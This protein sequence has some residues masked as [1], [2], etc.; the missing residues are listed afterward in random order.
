MRGVDRQAVFF[1]SRDHRLFLDTLREAGEKYGCAIHAYVLMTNHVH[2]LATPTSKGAIPSL[3]QA[4]GRGYVQRLNQQYRRTGTLWQGRYKASLV[5]DDR[6]LL[7]CQRYIE[8][9]PV[10]AGMVAGP[11]E[12]PWSSYACN[13]LGRPDPLVIPHPVY[14]DLNPDPE[15]R[16]AAYR[17]LFHDVLGDEVLT[18]VRDATNACLILGNDRFKDQIELLPGRSVRH[19][20]RGRRP[21]RSYK[22]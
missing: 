11:G 4:L 1:H 12:Y 3:M 22:D 21:G 14:Q 5:Q 17:R 19:R 13:A 7:T 15:H 2:L 18:R 9:N 20:K 16:R 6:Y 10:R 8:L